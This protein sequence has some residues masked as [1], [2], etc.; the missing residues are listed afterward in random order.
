MVG[1]G[2]RGGSGG[3][4]GEMAMGEG[5]LGVGTGSRVVSAGEE[6]VRVS[7]KRFRRRPVPA[8]GRQGDE[9]S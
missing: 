3:R 6:A 7:G 9:A 2:T 4:L 5:G 8:R 1:A